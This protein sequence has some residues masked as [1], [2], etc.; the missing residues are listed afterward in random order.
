[1]DSAGNLYGVTEFGGGNNG[2]GTIYE[3]SANTR[4]FN[5]LYTFDDTTGAQPRGTLSIDSA[6]NLYGTA[7]TGGANNDGTIFEFNPHFQQLTTLATFNGTNGSEPNQRLTFDS[8]GDIFGTTNRGGQN[9]SGT[10]FEIPAA[11]HSLTTLYSFSFF[12]GEFPNGGLV[13]DNVGNLYGTASFDS[14]LFKFNISTK[15]YTALLPPAEYLDG[16]SA[17]GMIMDSAGNLYGTTFL[18]GNPSPGVSGGGTV[19]EYA[20]KTNTFTTLAAF[21][22]AF[23]P[24]GLLLFDKSGNLWGT[25]SMGGPGAYGGPDGNY[26]SIFELNPK[27]EALDELVYLN[28]NNNGPEGGLT[29]DS[30]GNLYATAYDNGFGGSVFELSNFGYVPVPLPVP[31]PASLAFIALLSAALLVRPGTR[32]TSIMQIWI[33]GM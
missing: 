24:D 11:T 14:T 25:T 21:P 2:Y 1:M 12:T 29:C 31:E 26:G 18:G 10:I 28:E 4:A 33:H 22:Y 19:F 9:S 17:E 32:R 8:A 7:Y 15:S 30:A 6:G 16:A 5:T 13:L 23:D 20:P 3:I 27:T